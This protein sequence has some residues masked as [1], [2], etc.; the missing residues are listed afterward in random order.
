M[1]GFVEWVKAL[2]DKRRRQEDE[3]FRRRMHAV[4]TALWR[5][6]TYRAKIEV[7]KINKALKIVDA[8]PLVKSPD[9]D[10]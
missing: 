5:S 7:A 3:E 2:V 9:Q 10:A 6:P 4:S 1:I 8:K